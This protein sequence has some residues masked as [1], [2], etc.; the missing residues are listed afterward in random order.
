MEPTPILLAWKSHGWRSLIGY[1]SWVTD[2]DTT[3]P[4]NDDNNNWK[5]PL[6]LFRFICCLGSSAFNLEMDRWRLGRTSRGCL[7]GGMGGDHPVS[8]SFSRSCATAF[9][10]ALTPQAFLKNKQKKFIFL[11]N[12]KSTFTLRIYP[13]C[14]SVL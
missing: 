6:L 14:K 7:V 12:K 4:L 10:S 11:K 8:E 5:I 13:F 2:S 3:W 9:P 1:S